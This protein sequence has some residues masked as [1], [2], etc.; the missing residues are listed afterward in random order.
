MNRLPLTPRFPQGLDT[1]RALFYCL[2]SIQHL[3]HRVVLISR[4]IAELVTL[5]TH[6]HCS[7][8]KRIP[9][10]AHELQALPLP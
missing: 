1:A 3:R 5:P 2:F 9:R 4:E 8:V 10:R 6:S 7:L